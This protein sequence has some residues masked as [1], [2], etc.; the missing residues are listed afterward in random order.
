M[1]T[2]P[3]LPNFSPSRLAR[4]KMSSE[5]GLK[6][7]YVEECKLYYYSYLFGGH[8]ENKTQTYDYL[9]LPFRWFISGG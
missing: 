5:K 2:G 3:T 4:V 8:W 6:Y 1:L 7:V 9:I